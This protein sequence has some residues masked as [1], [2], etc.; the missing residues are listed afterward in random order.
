MRLDDDST[1]AI[2]LFSRQPRRRPTVGAMTVSL[3]RAGQ[4]YELSILHLLD[5]ALGDGQLWWIDQIIRGIN[6]HHRSFDRCE[7]R[8]R[9]VVAGSAGCVEKISGIHIGYGSFDGFIQV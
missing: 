8:R 1:F 9:I 5:F 7:F 2:Y 4:E 3:V 6:K